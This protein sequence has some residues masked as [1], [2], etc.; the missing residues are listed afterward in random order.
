MLAIL[1]G[2]LFT[3][4]FGG[5]LLGLFLGACA[6]D[7]ERSAK[8]REMRSIR[9][10]AARLPAFFVV[11]HPAP[12]DARVDDELLGHLRQ[13]LDAEQAVADE[14]V[15]HPSIESLYRGSERRLTAH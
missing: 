9:E 8:A 11:T 10:E 14:F 2:V 3:F 4:V 7:E 12:T 6:I 13:Y 5:L 1:I 15:L